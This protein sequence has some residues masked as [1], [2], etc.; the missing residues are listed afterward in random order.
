[1]GARFAPNVAQA[2]KSF[3]TQPMDLLGDIGRVESCFNP[4]GDIVRVSA[5]FAQNID[6]KSFW[7]APDGTSR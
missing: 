1:M 7:D 6:Q 2:Q 5:R 4:L 3:W